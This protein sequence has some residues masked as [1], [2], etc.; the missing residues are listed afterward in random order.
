MALRSSLLFTFS[1]V[2]GAA[3]AT[4]GATPP[5]RVFGAATLMSLGGSRLGL[6]KGEKQIYFRLPRG[7][8]SAQ[9]P[10]GAQRA[11]DGAPTK[12]GK[13]EVFTVR[14]LVGAASRIHFSNR[15]SGEVVRLNVQSHGAPRAAVAP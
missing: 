5:P 3:S 9:R 8:W 6:R 14:G 10:N 15:E 11:L 12:D 4:A 1:L 13:H 7:L 2:L